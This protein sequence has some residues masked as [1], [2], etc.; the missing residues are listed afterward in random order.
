M[1]KRKTGGRMNDM[2]TLWRTRYPQ[3]VNEPKH[4]SMLE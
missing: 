4:T 2:A 3:H 1:Q